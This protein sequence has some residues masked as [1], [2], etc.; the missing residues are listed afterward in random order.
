MWEHGESMQV[1]TNTLDSVHLLPQGENRFGDDEHEFD[2]NDVNDDVNG[3]DFESEKHSSVLDITMSPYVQ[4]GMIGKSTLEI[5]HDLMST[6]RWMHF[7]NH[8]VVRISVSGSDKR[9]PLKCGSTR[10]WIHYTNNII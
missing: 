6:V 2:L 10:E 9:D 1:R 3:I 5:D 4:P 7:G 8:N